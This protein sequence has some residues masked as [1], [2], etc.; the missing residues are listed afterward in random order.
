MGRKIEITAA[1]LLLAAV[2][3]YLSEPYEF[4]AVLLAAAIHELGHAAAIWMAGLRIKS[5]RAELRGF[6]MSYCGY[7][8]T[9][10]HIL[11]AAAGPSAGFLYAYA[12][13]RMGAELESRLL[14]LSSGVSLIL[15]AFNLL[16][17]MPLDG[18]R[19]FSQLSAAVLGEGKGAVLSGYVSF[20]VCTALF[21]AGVWLMLRDKGAALLITAVWMLFYQESGLGIVKSREIL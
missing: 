12:A 13:G 11:I 10:G 15:S 19:I 1:S 14:C 18:G 5:F 20:G 6:C 7:T 9:L 16:P 8:G 17:A 3:I 2:L 4:C 21:C